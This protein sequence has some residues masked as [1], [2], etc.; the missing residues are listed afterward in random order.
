MF[1]F[2]ERGMLNLKAPEQLLEIKK[3]PGGGP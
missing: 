3:G 1:F 2:L